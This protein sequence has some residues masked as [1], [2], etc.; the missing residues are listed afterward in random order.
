MLAVLTANRQQQGSLR[1]VILPASNFRTGDTTQKLS[2]G[3]PPSVVLNQGTVEMISGELAE[4]KHP[5]ILPGCSS[6]APA[7]A[8]NW[9]ATDLANPWNAVVIVQSAEIKASHVI[10]SHPEPTGCT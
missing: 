6:R 7:S 4:R 5:R 1:R 2:A 3:P 9:V 8:L 10:Q